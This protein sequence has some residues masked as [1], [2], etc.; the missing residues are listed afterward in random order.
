MDIAENIY[1]DVKE[2]PKI[3][4]NDLSNLVRFV[5]K[6]TTSHAN[7]D[8]QQFLEML[9]KYISASK[10]EELQKREQTLELAEQWMDNKYQKTF[11]RLATE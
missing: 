11:Q 8:H 4:V 6:E 10:Q 1:R 3:I 2:L 5:K 7:Y 9:Q